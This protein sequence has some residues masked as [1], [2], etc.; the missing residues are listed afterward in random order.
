MLLYSAELMRRDVGHLR[1]LHLLLTRHIHLGHEL[2]V[3]FRAVGV[4]ENGV[5]YIYIYIYYM[6]IKYTH[7]V[8][9]HIVYIYVY[10]HIYIHT[11]YI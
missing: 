8:Y 10:I 1:I 2:L 7:I 5:Y 6:N 3:D 9:I 11:I 4:S